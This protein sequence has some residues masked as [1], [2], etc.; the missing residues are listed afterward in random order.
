MI[1]W[2]N[3]IYNALWLSGCALALATLSIANYDA[4]QHGMRLRDRL[5][6]PRLQAA[7]AIAAVL[8]GAGMCAT[9]QTLWERIAWAALTLAFVFQ[10]I[11]SARSTNKVT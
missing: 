6:Q 8:F 10:F 9:S 3:L 7:L 4:R 2:L 1:D 5:K 11:W